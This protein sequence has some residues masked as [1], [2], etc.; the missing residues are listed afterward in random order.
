MLR[1]L[2]N[3]ASLLLPVVATATEEKKMTPQQ[4][5]ITMCNKAAREKKLDGDARKKFISECLKG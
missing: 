5:K 4:Q 3:V 2:L 1:K